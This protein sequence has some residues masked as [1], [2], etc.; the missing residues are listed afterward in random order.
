ML[1][2]CSFNSTENL[3]LTVTPEQRE[4]LQPLQGMPAYVALYLLLCMLPVWKIHD[5]E[6][7]LVEKAPTNYHNIAKFLGQIFFVDWPFTIFVEIIFD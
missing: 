7:C 4:P 3:D 6:F 5:K 1:A 2:L